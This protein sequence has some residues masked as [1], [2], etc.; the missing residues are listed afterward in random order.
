MST[1]NGYSTH[2]PVPFE[3]STALP[4]CPC[5]VNCFVELPGLGRVQVTGRGC[6]PS[7]SVA[8]LLGQ[9]DLLRMHFPEVSMQGNM[10]Q[11]KL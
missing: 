1:T 11:K 3:P 8:N 6:T 7:Q 2:T 10:A 4:E 5:S 9:I